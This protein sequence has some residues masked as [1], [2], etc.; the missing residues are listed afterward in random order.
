M[1]KT[2]L[3]D[4]VLIVS[5]VTGKQV[6]RALMGKDH[7]GYSTMRIEFTDGS[8]LECHAEGQVSSMSYTCKTT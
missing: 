1:E 5:E 7:I 2:E 4:D 8:W 3:T 6:K